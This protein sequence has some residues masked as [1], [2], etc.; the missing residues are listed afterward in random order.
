MKAN[1]LDNPSIVCRHVTRGE[2]VRIIQYGPNVVRVLKGENDASLSVVKE[3]EESQCATF[4]WDVDEM[5]RVTFRDLKGNVLLREDGCTAELIEDGV[6]EGLLRVKQSWCIPQDEALFGLGQ[7]KSEAINQRF[8]KCRL[9]TNNT[10]IYIP[11]FASVKGYG[12]YWDNIGETF[13]EGCD[14]GV[15]FRSSVA[16]GID[17]YFI[18][19]DGSQDGLVDGIRQLTGQARMLPLW[20]MGFWQCRERYR[21]PD[22]LAAT[23]DEYRRRGVP[24]D[25]IVQDWQYWGCFANWN[26]MKFQN[27]HFLDKIGDPEYMRFLPDEENAE[28]EVEKKR[29]QKPPRLKTPEEMID[30][31]HAQHARLMISVWPSFGDWTEQYKELER[32]GALLPFATYPKEHVR[33]M[34]PTNPEAL[35]IFCRHLKPLYNMGMDALWTDAVEPEHDE[36]EG[37][38]DYLTHGGS[39]R[40]VKNAFSLLENKQVYAALR[41][42]DPKQKRI[43]QMSRAASFGSQHYGVFSWSGDVQST[44]KEMKNQVP[45]GLSY[46][47]SGIPVWNT[48]LAGFRCGSYRDDPKDPWGQEINV[49]WRQWGTFQPVMRSHCSSPM[50][51]EIYQFGEPGDWAYDAI[52]GAIELRYSLLPYIYSTLGATVQRSEIMM[53]PFVMD[54]PNDKVAINRN[55][56]YMF[57]RALLV[58]PVTDPLYTWQDEERV[59]HFISPDNPFEAAS[60]EVYLPEGTDWYNFYSHKR[61]AGGTTYDVEAPIDRIPVFVRAGAILPRGPKV[62]YTGEKPWDN[63]HVFV[64]PG[65]DGDF[66]LYEDE[67]DNYNYEAG[68]FTQIRMHWNDA[69]RTLEIADREGRFDGMLEKRQFRIILVDGAQ[70]TVHYDGRKVTVKL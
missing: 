50:V 67:G 24:L 17:Y 58:K 68:M 4:K 5:G 48:D 30:Y 49:R 25:V 59:G 39:W 8:E 23:L 47:I 26:A 70:K 6:D 22:Q 11:Y 12:I 31:V 61:M 28:E 29:T 55:D 66:I 43:V 52:K 53:R 27:P 16:K 36:R 1:S 10:Y 63:L 51:P 37:D 20:A 42:T 46:S 14:E 21:S 32:I 13:Y 2:S 9:W 62:Q 44:W 40:S 33:I 34:D 60:V 38:E 7:R 57:G 54:F 18:Y 56:E 65:A 69:E 45:S 35:D 19:K 41:G 64:F 15:S 3:A